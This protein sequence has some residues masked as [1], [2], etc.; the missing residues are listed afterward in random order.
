MAAAT[1]TTANVKD[2]AKIENVFLTFF[3]LRSGRG[4]RSLTQYNS[5]CGR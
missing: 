2:V 5:D 3:S 1:M 4:E